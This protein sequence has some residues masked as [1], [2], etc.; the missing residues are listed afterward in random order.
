MVE[1]GA[2]WTL[3]AAP[4]LLLGFAVLAVTADAA[5]TARDAGR[6]VTVSA[7][8]RPLLA[9]PRALVAQPRRM[10]APDRMLW[11]AGVVSVPVA[12]VLSTL[13]IP[14][15]NV[16][17][18]DLSVGVVWFNAM[19]VM[20]WAGLWLAGWGPN[21]AFSLVGGYRFLAQGLAYELPLMFALI[22]TATG[23]QSLRVGDIAAA[24]YGLW[25]AVWMPVAFVVYLAG[26]LAFSFL[27]PFAYPVGQDIAGGVLSETSGVDRLMLQAGR[28][29]WLA[30]G[31]AMAVPLFLGGGAGP[32]L[33]AW[34]WSL[35]KTLLV[36]AALV[37]AVRRLPVIRADR[38]VEFA[39]VVLIPL[40]ILQALV[41]ALV[42]V[43][44]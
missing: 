14:F 4:A 44:R 34:A 17:V 9:V 24:Q 28:W 39:W 20:T 27:G 15:G 12:A 11:R 3:L 30:A 19:E 2:W 21:A 23:A 42:N 35:I 16:A 13:V 32:A 8:M 36:L 6:P 26:V 43:N 10:P 38:Y 31:A 37:A 18:A 40:T 22:S 1:A 25:Y 7:A 29:L 41:P 5:L 33:P